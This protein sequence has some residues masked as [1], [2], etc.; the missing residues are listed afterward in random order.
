MKNIGKFFFYYT[1]LGVTGLTIGSFFFLPTPYNLIQPIVLV[2][3]LL[4]F[5]LKI[6]DPDS[7]TESSWSGRIVV[8]LTVLTALMLFGYYLKSDS[9]AQVKALTLQVEQSNQTT[10]ASIS[11]ELALLKQELVNMKSTRD[12]ESAASSSA[13]SNDI[14]DLLRSLDPVKPSATPAP[15]MAKIIIGQVQIAGTSPINVYEQNN[16]SS[17]II[18]VA[19]GQSVYDYYESKGKHYLIKLGETQEGWVEAENVIEM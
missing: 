2:P 11:A 5:W 13:N 7:A 6:T 14:L 4:F 17:K 9:K 15:V 10:E 8:V 18:G 19:E 3:S 12:V 16:N 1:V